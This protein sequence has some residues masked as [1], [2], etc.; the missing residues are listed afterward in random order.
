MDGRV[1]RFYWDVLLNHVL[2]YAITDSI[3]PVEPGRMRNSWYPRQKAE[4]VTAATLQGTKP[5]AVVAER[6]FTFGIKAKKDEAPEALR[7]EKPAEMN[8]KFELP[9]KLLPV[10]D[11]YR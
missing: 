1:Q 4:Y 7:E 6:D 11:L 2:T 9:S 10:I 5:Q 8:P 3:T